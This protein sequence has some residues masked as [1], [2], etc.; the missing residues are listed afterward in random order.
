M[1]ESENPAVDHGPH[2]FLTRSEAADLC[3][4]RG[5]KWFELVRDGKAPAPT[6]TIGRRPLWSR[7]E[8]VAW[9]KAGAP[10][11]AAWRA[12]RAGAELVVG[13]A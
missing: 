11:R 6:C 9:L 7:A 10:D 13:V 12:M 1:Y 2:E 3:R 5:T 4:M 8:L